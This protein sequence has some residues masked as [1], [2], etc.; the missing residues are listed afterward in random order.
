MIAEQLVRLKVR[1]VEGVPAEEHPGAGHRGETPQRSRHGRAEPGGLGAL[2]PAQQRPVPA[3]PRIR[4]H[5]DLGGL[6][7][8]GGVGLEP[9]AAAAPARRRPDEALEVAV[10]AL[11]VREIEARIREPLGP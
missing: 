2:E 4:Q 11:D 9:T 3:V 10:L 5:D 8:A 7:V 6:L 1:I